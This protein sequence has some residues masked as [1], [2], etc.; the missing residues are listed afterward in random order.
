[1]YEASRIAGKNDF[2]IKV[3][4]IKGYLSALLPKETDDEELKQAKYKYVD[5]LVEF[6]INCFNKRI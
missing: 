5:N 1:M 2:E 6:L 3:E 4:I